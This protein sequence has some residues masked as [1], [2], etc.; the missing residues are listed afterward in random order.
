M[1]NTFL[2]CF[3]WFLL[4]STFA[5]SSGELVKAPTLAINFLLSDFKTADLINKSS[6]GAVLNNRDWSRMKDMKAGLGFQYLQGWNKYVDFSG[7]LN[8]SFL[9]Y[10]FQNKASL[11]T[12]KLL[13]ETEAALHA[14]LLPD[15]Y[16]IVPYASAGLA[17]GLYN[18]YFLSYMP[19][20]A[21]LQLNLGRSDAF[22]FSQ[23]H[24]FIPLTKTCNY[25]FLYSMG[26]AANLKSA[27]L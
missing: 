19:V 7:R 5:Q 17:A 11:G 8:I 26:F 6:V 15:K 4:A 27:R 25:R 12:E 14:K 10:P 3:C 13:L 16:F 24:Y 1:K 9:D 18:V 22:I 2:S 23:M 20:G 21:G